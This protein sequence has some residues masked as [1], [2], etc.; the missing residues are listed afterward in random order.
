MTKA[1]VAAMIALVMVAGSAGA[2]LLQDTTGGAV[3]YQHDEDAE[4]DAADTCSG[5]L[6]VHDKE[7]TNETREIAG[8]LVPVDDEADYYG[9]NATADILGDRIRVTVVSNV[10]DVGL[11]VFQPEC[12]ATVF[13]EPE[14][15][16]ER[17]SAPAP[18]EGNKTVE[19]AVDDF[20]CNPDEWKFMLKHGKAHTPPAE[21]YV[22]WGRPHGDEAVS[23][24]HVSQG[25]VAMYVTTQNL[26]Y[27]VQSM[28]AEVPEAWDESFFMLSHGPCDTQ[29]WEAEP[30]EAGS[31]FVEFTALRTGTYGVGI[32]SDTSANVPIIVIPATC[33]NLCLDALEDLRDEGGYDTDILDQSEENSE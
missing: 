14:D 17:P 8:M 9:I 24:T 7:L 29:T 13:E 28:K 33:H 20:D 27:T 3:N 25:Q 15:E 31:N 18:D 22:D 23:L 26:E 21:I 2:S 16:V 4:T 30:P 11:T 10:I 19:G 1:I 6:D 12:Q 5:I 32:L